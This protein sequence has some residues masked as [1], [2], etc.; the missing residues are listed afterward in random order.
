M[1][2]PLIQ[3]QLREGIQAV[4]Q[5]DRRRGEALLLQVVAA[6]EGNEPAWLWLSQ[7]VTAPVDQLAALEH[8]LRLNPDN[9]AARAQVQALREQLG[10]EPPVAPPES[11]PPE[12]EPA[13]LPAAP[14][15]AFDNDPDQCLYCGQLTEPDAG[16]CPYCHRSLLQPGPTEAAAPYRW[17]I[18][19][20]A[21]NLQL[22]IVLPG[23]A[24]AKVVLQAGNISA[25]V[26]S[27][28]S[29]AMLGHMLLWLVA[30]LVILSSP[31]A[32]AV[33]AAA[34]ALV[35]VS[36]S[37][38]SWALG[39]TSPQ[40]AAILAVLDLLLVGLGFSMLLNS[41]AA[42]VRQ[43]VVLDRN[44]YGHAELYRRGYRYAREGKWALAALHLQKAMVLKPAIAEYYKDLSFAQAQLGRYPQALRTLRAGAEQLPEDS[45][46][47][48]QIAALEARLA[49]FPRP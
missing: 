48:A 37:G 31:S 15:D 8:A 44:A 9:D 17:L 13:A 5:G 24:L 3:Q 29:Y 23:L 42:R 2:P 46:F 40:L 1:V 49:S 26:Y 45:E 18:L 41:A 10:F 11:P 39:W 28:A 12:A 38:V 6:D 20:S 22:N 36:F 16:R 34:F 43:R 27:A 35:D 25:F 4:R 14:D 33:A 21:A 47:P 7:A 19:F 32:A 30:F